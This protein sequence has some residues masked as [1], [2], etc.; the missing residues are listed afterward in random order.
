[1]YNAQFMI[2]IHCVQVLSECT[3][4]YNF[5]QFSKYI[6]VQNV[7]SSHPVFCV[8]TINNL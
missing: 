7:L 3:R 1:M 8:G 6:F 5:T 2:G 4:M